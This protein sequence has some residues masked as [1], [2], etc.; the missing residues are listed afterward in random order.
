MERGHQNCPLEFRA[1]YAGIRDREGPDLYAAVED[2]ELPGFEPSVSQFLDRL[3][4][5]DGWKIHVGIRNKDMG[6]VIDLN[7][8]S[9]N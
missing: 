7:A 3:A 2:R 4:E 1:W 8:S 6:R 5:P 9:R